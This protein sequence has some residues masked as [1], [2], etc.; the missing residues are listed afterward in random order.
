M[1]VS[2]AGENGGGR[3]MPFTV[4]YL[5]G[6]KGFTVLAQGRVD[7]A[8]VVAM[9]REIFGRDL[10][11]QPYLYGLFDTTAVTEFAVA[12]DTVQEAAE[13]NLANARQ[14]PHF[15]LAVYANS[16]LTFGI[17]RMWAALIE[18]G[19]WRTNVFRDRDQAVR[20]I[21]EQV[22]EA[23]GVDISLE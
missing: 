12:R 19:G 13:Y 2:V 1:A 22:A 18:E 14:M 15:A 21:K 11:A 7:R 9:Q 8:D 20:W 3:A 6:G 4:K 10:V 23:S 16:D 5:D 17:A